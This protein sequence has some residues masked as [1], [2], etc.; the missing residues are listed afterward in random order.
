MRRKSITMISKDRY[1][2]SIEVI[3]TD[4][5]LRFHVVIDEVGQKWKIRK[6]DILELL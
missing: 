3:I 4:T 2:D 6:K 5:Y 1:K